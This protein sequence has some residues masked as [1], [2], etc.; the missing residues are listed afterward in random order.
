[1]FTNAD[2][3]H[4]LEQILKIEKDMKEIFLDFQENVQEPE[5]KKTF[6]SLAKDEMNH[7]AIVEELMSLFRQ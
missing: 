4:F 7:E 6:G 2:F 1:M 5:F 3:M